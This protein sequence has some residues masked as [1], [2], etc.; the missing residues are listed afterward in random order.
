MSEGSKIDVFN[1]SFPTS[2][3]HA[4]LAGLSDHRNYWNFGYKALMINDTSF[5]RNPNYHLPSDSIDTLDFDKMTQVIDGA[6][7]A[8]IKI[9]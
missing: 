5:I 9:I 1:I 7:N 6:Y 2:S 4:G 3:S 8:I